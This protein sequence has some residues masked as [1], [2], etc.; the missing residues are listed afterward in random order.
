MCIWKYPQYRWKSGKQYTG[1]QNETTNLFE[2][3][4]NLDITHLSIKQVIVHRLHKK[5]VAV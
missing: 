5:W 1:K 2:P 3:W 4:I